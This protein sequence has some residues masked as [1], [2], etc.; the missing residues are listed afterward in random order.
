G[1]MEFDLY[2]DRDTAVA[3]FTALARG[4]FGVTRD[5]IQNSVSRGVQDVLDRRAARSEPDKA[6]TEGQHQQGTAKKRRLV[7]ARLADIAP[8]PVQWFWPN[9]IPRKFSLFT[10]PP[11][12]GKTVTVID[13][14][15]RSTTGQMWPDG[16]GRAPL[17]HSIFLTA[18][19]GLA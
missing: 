15:S 3:H 9:R 4:R 2:P 5:E 1:L 8:Q 6:R 11:D 10:G 14:M 19:D 18:E 16:S 12:C 13:L 17:G 7:F